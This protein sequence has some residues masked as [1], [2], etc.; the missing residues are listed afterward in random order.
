VEDDAVG[1]VYLIRKDCLRIGAPIS[2]FVFQ[3]Y[4]PI[5]TA[6]C[7]IEP[8]IGSEVYEPRAGKPF[9]EDIDIKAL[10][11][12]DLACLASGENTNQAHLAGNRAVRQNTTNHDRNYQAD[13]DQVKEP[14]SSCLH[15]TT[16][17][18][19]VASPECMRDLRR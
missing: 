5:R 15:F 17:G 18:N 8:P 7:H 10:W 13:P 4:D 1:I 6:L 2:V 9:S 19:W 3:D 11:Y 14:S 16:S 12:V